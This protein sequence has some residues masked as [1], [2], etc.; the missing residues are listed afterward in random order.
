KTHRHQNHRCP[1]ADLLIRGNQ[2]DDDGRNPHQHEG[3]QQHGFA[4]DLVAEVPEHD[5][6][7]WPPEKPHGIGGE[8]RQHT[9]DRVERGKEDFVEDQGGSCAVE[10][11]VVPLDGRARHARSTGK[12]VGLGVPGSAGIECT[13]VRRYSVLHK[14]LRL[15]IVV[16][17]VMRC[18][19]VRF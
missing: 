13:G 6:A 3:E 18:G 17:G 10:E 15:F 9:D 14:L 8:S 19:V 4:T 5:S 7:Q 12:P 1:V 2:A 11:K 16:Q